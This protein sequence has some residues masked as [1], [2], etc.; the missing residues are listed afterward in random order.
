MLFRSLIAEGKAISG[1]GQANDPRGSSLWTYDVSNLSR[2]GPVASLR[3]GAPIDAAST[4]VV[5][6]AAPSAV[7]ASENA[8]YVALA[9]E[10]AVAE[11]SADGQSLK[12]QI[13]L[14]PFLRAGVCGPWWQPVARCDAKRTGLDC[15]S[16]VCH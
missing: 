9:H 14:S 6:G 1:I 11:I 12:A 10:D 16:L 2:A 7:V 4:H 8:V 15:R 3:L 13:P 5:G